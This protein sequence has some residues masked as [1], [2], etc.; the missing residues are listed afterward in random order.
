MPSV[1]IFQS[2]HLSPAFV[3]SISD[4]IGEFKGANMDGRRFLSV[5]LHVTL[6][7]AFSALR[8]SSEKP[9]GTPGIDFA[10]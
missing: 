3:Q 9:C 4:W 10:V 7:P 6:V 8:K 1:L 5:Q 2:K